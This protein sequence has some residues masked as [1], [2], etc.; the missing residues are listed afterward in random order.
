MNLNDLETFLLVV[1]EGTFSGAAERLGVPKSTVSRRVTRLEEDLGLSLLRRSARSFEVS[2]TGH[3]LYERCLPAVREI[4]EVERDL[5]D[6]EAAP[7]GLLRLTTSIDMGSSDFLSEL[8]A[9]F[10]TRY[11]RVRVDLLLANRLVD[12]VEENVDLALRVHLNPPVDRDEL[13]ARVLG[14][15]TVG[16]YA[17]PRYLER[18]GVPR[19]VGELAD[20]SVVANS[21]D[22][23]TP[24]AVA[25][26]ITADD[27]GSVAAILA[28][29]AG[30]GVLPDFVAA[31]H[32][33]IGR[34]VPVLPDWSGPAAT[35]YLVWLRSRHLAPRVR[36]FIDMTAEYAR[37]HPFERS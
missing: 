7:V 20:H 12:L 17:H 26:A 6:T 11:P 24:G 34:L 15:I 33:R 9:R 29:G 31:P 1:D 4:A 16:M 36:A 13:I 25:P 32:M 23:L 18:A 30:V 22:P 19:S 37:L 3:A 2:D 14:R 21:R 28:A 27:Y 10:T 8:L 5:G 35:A